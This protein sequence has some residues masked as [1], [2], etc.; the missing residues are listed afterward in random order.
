[1]FPD[2]EGERDRPQESETVPNSILIPDANPSEDQATKGSEL[3]LAKEAVDTQ[4]FSE[5]QETLLDSETHLKVPI[6][7]EPMPLRNTDSSQPVVS[8]PIGENLKS[9]EGN[10]DTINLS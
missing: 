3:E 2:A 8:T 10:H 4:D 6:V 5:N 9:I 1:M 7:V